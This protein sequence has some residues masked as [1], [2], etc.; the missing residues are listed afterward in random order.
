M[1]DI[2]KWLETA[3]N[4]GIQITVKESYS[5]NVLSTLNNGRVELAEN[6]PYWSQNFFAGMRVENANDFSW[7]GRLEVEKR[8]KDAVTKVDA[9]DATDRDIFLWSGIRGYDDVGFL[10]YQQI[11]HVDITNNVYVNGIVL[12]TTV[13]NGNTTIFN[14]PLI[15]M[16]LGEQK[17][18]VHTPY[19]IRKADID[20]I[21]DVVNNMRNLFKNYILPIPIPFSEGGVKNHVKSA[22]GIRGIVSIIE[23]AMQHIKGIAN[24]DT[25]D[26]STTYGAKVAFGRSTV[27]QTVDASVT[28]GST[29]A[30]VTIGRDGSLV[31]EGGARGS[32]L[33]DYVIALAMC[34]E[35]AGGNL[36][37]VMKNVDFRTGSTINPDPYHVD[38]CTGFSSETPPYTPPT[39][40]EEINVTYTFSEEADGTVTVTYQALNQDNEDVT[41]QFNTLSVGS[42]FLHK[43]E[44]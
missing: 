23:D 8:L 40:E 41:S 32:W 15:E 4:A 14:E 39:E 16:L 2:P 12:R 1:L 18:T 35:N 19:L 20:L 10:A 33:S 26:I 31:E 5:G 38:T 25:L 28:V 24:G 34:Y 22:L 29:V 17:L 30:R 42:S 6:A 21:Q 9:T 11:H 13:A 44:L 27:T 3:S 7:M 43:G 36:T 37:K